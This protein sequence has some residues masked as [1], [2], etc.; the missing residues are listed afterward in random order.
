M[1]FIF[2]VIQIYIAE[3]STPSLRGGL[4]SVNQLAVTLGILYSYVMGVFLKWNLLAIVEAIPPT[5]LIILM[6]FMPETPR[7]L[8]AHNRRHDALKALRWLRGSH[9]DVEEECCMIES[10][11]GMFQPFQMLFVVVLTKK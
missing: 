2:C 3:I 8:L 10:N 11:L 5:L 4:G 1:D 6:F 7:W 9:A